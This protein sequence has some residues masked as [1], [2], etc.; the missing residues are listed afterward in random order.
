MMSNRLVAAAIG[1]FLTIVISTAPAFAQWTTAQRRPERP[2]RGLFASGADD[3]GQSLIAS[4]SVGGGYDS[5]VFAD[6]GA[7]GSGIVNDPR[8]AR[9]GVVGSATGA[10]EYALRHDRLDVGASFGDAFRYYPQNSQTSINSYAETAGIDYHASRRTSFGATQYVAYQPFILSLFPSFFEPSPGEL[11]LPPIDLAPGLVSYLTY[12]AG[13]RITHSLSRRVSMYGG[14]NAERS[15]TPYVNTSLSQQGGNAGVRVGLS[16]YVGLRMGYQ[17][18]E[19][20]YAGRANTVVMETYDIGIDLQKALSVSRRTTLSL[21]S[22]TSA[23]ENTQAQNNVGE[24]TY[25]ITGSARLNHEIGRTWHTSVGY[26]RSVQFVDTLLAPVLSDSISGNLGGL[27]SRRVDFNSGV[28]AS[29]GTV[30]F[31]NPGAEQR[32]HTY[33]GFASLGYA[34][35]RTANLSLSYSAYTY[36]FDTQT[37]LPTGI[38]R[39]F[40]RQSVRLNLN[41][42]KPLVNKRRT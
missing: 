17:R 26:D 37:L 40:G 35:N 12:G 11:N 24:R 15:N 21:A 38:A 29:F 36:R 23:I 8:F 22:G 25:F 39:D 32:F 31:S 4:G 42:W 33:Q 19:G 14:Y 28:Q 18:L 7:A 41:L 34:F 2:Y 5:N 3:A 9:P 13:A 27:F 16:K 6:L 30:G 1:G 20:R 10:L